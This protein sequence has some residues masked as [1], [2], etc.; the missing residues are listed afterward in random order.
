MCFCVFVFSGALKI[1][2]GQVGGRKILL[3]NLGPDYI[4][5]GWLA[6]QRS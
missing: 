4:N 5:R 6:L 1:W 3:Q 2:L